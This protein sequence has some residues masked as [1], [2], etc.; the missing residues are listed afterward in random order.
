MA[1]TF[2][3]DHLAIKHLK[4]VDPRLAKWI[5]TIGPV[6]LQ[7]P[8]YDYSTTLAEM[9]VAQQLSG[10]V[11][12]VIW[13]RVTTRFGFPLDWQ[14]LASSSIDDLRPLGLSRGK[15]A[16]LINLAKHV[17]SEPNYFSTLA[18]LGDEEVIHRL[19]ALK[20]VGPWTAHMFL[21][22]TLHRLDVS[23]AGDL[24]L[25]MGLTKLYNLSSLVTAKEFDEL[26]YRWSPYRSVAALYLWRA[27]DAKLEMK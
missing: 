5:D 20:G 14:S 10:K 7:E 13:G 22:F 8:H 21:I 9:I 19:T 25:K 27:H 4:A 12:T 6:Q 17:E 26:T 24:G 16:Y 1:I 2:S 18:T 3:H 15:A 23:A 11:A